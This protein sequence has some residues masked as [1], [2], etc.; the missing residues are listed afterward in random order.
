METTP[1]LFVISGPSGAGKGTIVA[2]I[3][4]LMPNLALTV[5]AT[6]RKPRDGEVNGESYYFLSD[7]AF[8]DKVVQDAFLEWAHVHGHCYG[9]LKSE[10]ERHINTGRSVIFEIDPQGAFN[11]K[12][13]YPDAVLIFIMPPSL[14]VLKER[15]VHRGSE[16][17]RSLALRLHNAA[18]EMQLAP[19]YSFT[20]VNDNLDKA[21]AKLQSI[22]QMCETRERN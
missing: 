13:I 16:D 10:V 5:S 15:L 7:K 17:E 4:E 21:V 9:T 11:V 3:R 19:R 8:S 2:R 18:Q 6:T 20:I 12:A 14:Q 22:I 1:R